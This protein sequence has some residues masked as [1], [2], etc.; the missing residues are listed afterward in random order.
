MTLLQNNK[1]IHLKVKSGVLFSHFF[2]QQRPR[3][4]RFTRL[5]ALT[6]GSVLFTDRF[7]PSVVELEGFLLRKR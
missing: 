3:R 5:E 4:E 6:A 7:L 1:L 2:F